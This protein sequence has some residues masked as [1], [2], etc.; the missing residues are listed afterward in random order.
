MGE[1]L[2]REQLKTLQR[3]RRD[4]NDEWLNIR[5]KIRM[6]IMETKNKTTNAV[7]QQMGGWDKISK[8]DEELPRT[9]VHFINRYVKMGMYLEGIE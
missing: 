8:T 9:R 7:I 5:D 4:S 6:G 2:T 1:K 3:L